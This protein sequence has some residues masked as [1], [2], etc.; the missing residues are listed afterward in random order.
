[1]SW[2]G[3]VKLKRFKEQAKRTFITS[4]EESIDKIRDKI[5][6]DAKKMG[7]WRA[8]IAHLER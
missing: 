7:G 6:A 2:K 4:V 3:K 8:Y 5:F 1:M